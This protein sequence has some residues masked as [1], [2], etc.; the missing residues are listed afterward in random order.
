MWRTITAAA[1][2]IT[3][4]AACSGD[5]SEADAQ[6]VGEATSTNAD[7]TTGDVTD[8]IEAAGLQVVNPRDNSGNCEP[9]GGSLP[10]IEQLTTDLFSV[11]VWATPE[12]A[13]RA[14][15]VAAGDAPVAVG[16]TTTVAFHEGG[17]TPTYD[18]AAYEAAL[19]ELTG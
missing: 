12:D 16:N 17:T 15:Q 13:Q 5:D 2:L 19:A 7:I 8:A 1:V 14:I 9:E 18:R 10:C 3:L 6:A 4:T 11:T